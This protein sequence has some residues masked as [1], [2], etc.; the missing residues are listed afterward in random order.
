MCVYV[1]LCVRMT[2]GCRLPY[3]RLHDVDAA[4]RRRL[5]NRHERVSH[6]FVS[7]DVV[8]DVAVN[9]LHSLQVPQLSI[10]LHVNPSTTHAQELHEQQQK[11]N[12]RVCSRCKTHWV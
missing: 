10:K 12:A 3:Q 1:C 2:S 4:S 6:T 7:T 8:W 11:I 5:P 9:V